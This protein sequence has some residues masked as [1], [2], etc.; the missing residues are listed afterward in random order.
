MN[1]FK[2]DSITLEK[3]HFNLI[4][5]IL[6]I[7][8]EF[9]LDFNITFVNPQVYD[10]LGYSP[11][12]LKGKKVMDFIHQDDL[13][14]I[15]ESIKYGL[16]TR[17][18]IT[19]NFLIQHKKGYYIPVSAK[20]R[21]VDY[22]NQTKIVAVIRDLIKEKEAEQ[23]LKESDE[24]YR[25]IIENIED[26]YYEIDLEG[27][28]TYVND[29]ICRFLGI[30]KEKLLGMNSTLVL[31][32]TTRQEIFKIFSNMYEKNLLKETFESQVIRNDG[33]IRTFEGTVYLKYNSSGAKVG[34]FGFT[35]DITEKKEVEQKLKESE[36][37]Y[38]NGYNR[39]ELYKNLFYHDINN[40]FSNIK[41]SVDLSKKYLGE[42]GREKDIEAL[43]N[44]IENQF[45]K[46]TKLVANV[47][48]AFSLDQSKISLKSMEAM[49]KLSEAIKFIHN[50]F[51]EKNINIKVDSFAKRIHIQTDELLNDVFDNLLINAITYNN[52][53]NIEILIKVTKMI[54]NKIKFIKFQ[55]IDN[56]IGI[57]Q[58][59]KDLIFQKGSI[60]EKDSKGLG[61][62][63]TLVKNIIDNYNGKIWVE[64]KVKDDYSR[65]SNFIVL[66]P[67]TP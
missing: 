33:E 2:N 1:K 37:R 30:S 6:D 10:L 9:D 15:V 60:K 25:E 3:K 29:Y 38:K 28:Y 54:K 35:H 42:S 45:I 24:R 27:N 57:T 19:E 48:K 11:E 63:L 23:K 39:A 43:Y 53:N 8:V 40:I 65:G 66:I 34:F 18:I 13:S 4:N 36:E 32:E 52:N 21:A 67:E 56:G 7:I 14:R 50:S 41:L 17:E 61:F 22:E 59:K 46:G 55:F 51:H 5:S 16:K 49:K 44:I 12:K 20:G 64:D 31:E 47:G 26:G 58:D 62:G